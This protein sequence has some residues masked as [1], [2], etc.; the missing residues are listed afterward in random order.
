MKRKRI[1]VVVDEELVDRLDK[2]AGKESASRATVVRRL[3][4]MGLRFVEEHGVDTWRLRGC[5][6]EPTVR[7]ITFKEYEAS[8]KRHGGDQKKMLRELYPP[9]KE[10]RL[11]VTFPKNTARIGKI[12]RSN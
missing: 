7:S 5:K 4:Y 1:S 9:T 2:A 3:L 12:K 11:K 8:H 10:K 6:I